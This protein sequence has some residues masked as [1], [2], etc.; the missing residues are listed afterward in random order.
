MPAQNTFEEI[1]E[2]LTFAKNI[3]RFLSDPDKAL[4]ARTSKAV[5]KPL[6]FLENP[7][8]L[9]REVIQ[10]GNNLYPPRTPG[11]VTQNPG[12]IMSDHIDEDSPQSQTLKKTICP[13]FIITIPVPLREDYNNGDK[14]PLELV[15]IYLADYKKAYFSKKSEQEFLQNIQDQKRLHFCFMLNAKDSF[16]DSKR[17]TAQIHALLILKKNHFEK[18]LL[19]KG[20]ASFVDI[21][22]AL[23]GHY[24]GIEEITTQ[25]DSH[26]MLNS[27]VDK[28][29]AQIQFQR[30]NGNTSEKI[31]TSAEQKFPFG[32][33]RKALVT[34]KPYQDSATMMSKHNSEL[35]TIIGDAD[36]CGLDLFTELRKLILKA[37]KRKKLLI[38]AGGGYSF[39]KQDIKACLQKTHPDLIG[40]SLERSVEFTYL[41]NSLDQ[42][43]RALLSD[44]DPHVAYFSE[45][46]QVVSNTLFDKNFIACHNRNNEA[47]PVTARLSNSKGN[48]PD[49]SSKV[50]GIL[51]QPGSYVGD[52]KPE[53]T[54]QT[55][56]SGLITSA[57][58]NE[59]LVDKN[60]PIAPDD[61][62]REI[63]KSANSQ[64]KISQISQ[65]FIEAGYG[66]VWPTIIQNIETK[67]FPY[68]KFFFSSNKKNCPPPELSTNQKGRTPQGPTT[69]IFEAGQGT[70]KFRT[71][72][73]QKSLTLMFRDIEKLLKDTCQQALKI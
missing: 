14:T 13:R 5:H 3:Y 28:I 2:N 71:D 37:K 45:A 48:M 32:T 47:E 8:S 50:A 6:Q 65:R 68:I 20:Y 19:E 69:L 29:R 39:S 54:I 21:I 36:L 53:N 1:F 24:P 30:E 11:K 56:F 63:Q 46:L 18:Q 23:W 17:T 42:D 4:L 55:F 22:P 35:Y 59:A 26:F 33:I 72:R 10:S 40:K 15:E 57:R 51:R 60:K 43:F 9:T 64:V 16:F 58:H 73:T 27:T 12:C 66:N 70:K 7:E 49:I 38:R 31:P 44:F 52:I 34:C 61:I 62:K 67:D 41:L 25:A